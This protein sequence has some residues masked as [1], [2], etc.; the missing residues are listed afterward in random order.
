MVLEDGLEISG[1]LYALKPLRGGVPLG[2]RG[3]E[4]SGGIRILY[5]R[6]WATF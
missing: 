6:E 3:E 5:W 1:V 4:G 2:E